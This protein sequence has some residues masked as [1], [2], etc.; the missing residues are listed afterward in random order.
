L[1]V[2]LVGQD[3]LGVVAGPGAAPLRTPQ[4][5]VAGLAVAGADQRIGMDRPG[6]PVGGSAAARDPGEELPDP[7]VLAG[8]PVSSLE[9]WPPDSQVEGAYYGAAGEIDAERPVRVPP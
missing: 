5:V 1:G 3:Q 6:R 2:Q 8:E 7:G 9:I 4:P